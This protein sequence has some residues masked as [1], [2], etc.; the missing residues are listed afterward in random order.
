MGIEPKGLARFNWMIAAMLWGF[1]EAT[2]FFVVPDVLLTSAVLIGGVAFA[3]RLAGWA[4]GAAVI[5]GMIMYFWGASD[6]PAARDML[7]TVPLVGPDLLLRVDAEMTGAWPQNVFTGALSGAPYKIYA[8]EAGAQE[9]N[10]LAFAVVSFMARFARFSIAIALTAAG[11]ALARAVG[12]GSLRAPGL[13]A[14]WAGI[15]LLYI[16]ARTGAG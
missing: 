16:S 11:F 4:A 2:A 1:A 8:V 15:Y 7:L 13:A 10:V 6:A 12:L 14:I 5:G 3:L 9:I